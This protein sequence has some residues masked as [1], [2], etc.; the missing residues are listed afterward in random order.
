[1]IRRIVVAA[2]LLMAV[3]TIA[4]PADS[5][6]V[7]PDDYRVFDADGQAASLDALVEAALTADVLLLG[8]EHTDATG[9]ALRAEL[10]ARLAE[11]LPE[12]R[13]LVLSL[14]MV[15]RDAQVV[16]QEYV[17]GLIREQDFL[18]A[19]RP[20]ANYA[21]AYRPLVELVRTHGGMAL[22]ANVPTRYANLVAREGL[23]ALDALPDAAKLLYLP[24][25]PIEPASEAY[26]E[27][28]RETMAAMADA[29]G[30]HGAHG[31][32]IDR[33]LDAQNLRD[34]TM[35]ETVRWALSELERP[36]VVHIN[37]AFHSEGGLGVPEHLARLAPE[38]VVLTVTM[39][40]HDAFPER[41][42]EAFRPGDDFVVV[43]VPNAEP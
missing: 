22:A 21:E 18:A 42:A 15:E 38:A 7:S 8:E 2:L 41:D 29:H 19:S 39:R 33:M 36:L 13:T 28:F 32:D 3:P 11:A 25:L 30:G 34:A 43:V 37:G 12:N 40:P 27:A 5:L 35:A 9:H 17:E 24:P 31:M 26:A 23:G 20:W 6:R 4:Q 1:M 14:E 16:L 10:L